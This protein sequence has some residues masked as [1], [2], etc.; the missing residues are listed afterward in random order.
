MSECLDS[1]WGWWCQCLNSV[2][3]WWCQCLDSVWGWWCQS[4]LTVSEGGDVKSVLS[5]SEAGDVKSVL[6]VSEAGDVRVSWQCL[7]VVMSVSWQCLRVVMSECLDSVWGWWCQECLVSVWGWWCQ[8][9]L[10]VSEGGN[11]M[12]WQCLRVVMS[13]CLDNVWGWRCLSWQCLRVVMSERLDSVW[14][15]WCQSVLTVSEGGDEGRCTS[16]S[17]RFWQVMTQQASHHHK[18]NHQT[19]KSIKTW[20]RSISLNLVSLYYTPWHCPPPPLLPPPPPPHSHTHTQRTLLSCKTTN[21]HQSHSQQFRFTPS[22][23]TCRDFWRCRR[24]SCEATSWRLDSAVPSEWS[25]CLLS[26]PWRNHVPLPATKKNKIII[27]RG[28]AHCKIL[29]KY[30][31]FGCRPHFGRIAASPIRKMTQ[32]RFSELRLTGGCR[33]TQH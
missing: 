9:V 32:H 23:W 29:R 27:I 30:C 31:I 11:W 5:V 8:S 28:R 10:T 25:C 1:V 24:P 26:G 18:T 15:W 7:R 21:T 16:L 17:V 12:S 6:S 20:H 22:S 4:V 3:R 33:V 14:G 2:W 19:C 13:E